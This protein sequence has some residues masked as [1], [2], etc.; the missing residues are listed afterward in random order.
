MVEKYVSCTTPPGSYDSPNT[1]VG[2]IRAM[3]EKYVSCTTPPG[4]ASQND[5][6]T[7]DAS[8]FVI[9]PVLL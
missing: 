7:M 1:I 9:L 2:G 3:V 6:P 8:S 5:T 4:I